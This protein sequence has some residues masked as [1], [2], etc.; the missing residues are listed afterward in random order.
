[1]SDRS[2]VPLVTAAAMAQTEDQRQS[3][4][5]EPATTLPTSP[6]AVVPW[7][8]RGQRQPRKLSEEAHVPAFLPFAPP[9]TKVTGAKRRAASARQAQQKKRWRRSPSLSP[10]PS[11]PPQR[12]P[13]KAAGKAKAKPKPQLSLAQIQDEERSILAAI[14]QAALQK[15]LSPELAGDFQKQLDELAVLKQQLQPTAHR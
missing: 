13:A 12:R 15:R 9:A 11:P 3:S 4:V 14:N 7:S 8:T 1:M 6:G 2:A 10:S 5:L